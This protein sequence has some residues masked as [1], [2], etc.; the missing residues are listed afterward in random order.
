MCNFEG[1]MTTANTRDRILD[2]AEMLF[3]EDGLHA[4]SIRQIAAAADVPFGLVRYHFE[5]KDGL[6]R[7]VFNRRSPI[8]V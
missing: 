8:I 4:V 7:A 3:A 5:S 1:A 6:Y 2:A